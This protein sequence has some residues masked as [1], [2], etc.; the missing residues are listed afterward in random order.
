VSDLPPA[1]RESDFSAIDT[2]DE[3]EIRGRFYSLVRDLHSFLNEGSCLSDIQQKRL[4]WKSRVLD[5]RAFGPSFATEPRHWYTYN[6]GGRNEAQFNI[7][8]SPDYLRVGLGFEFTLKK[9]GDPTIVHWVYAQF[10]KVI[11]R[12]TQSFEQFVRLNALEV[13]WLPTDDVS[14]KLVSTRRVLKWLLQPPRETSWI[15]VGRLL[16]RGRDA[17]I[18]ND[19]TELRSVIES[20]FEG[21]IPIWE[22]TQIVAA[23][24]K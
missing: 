4:K 5:Q 21:F 15:F 7:G 20:V 3:D 18:L 24:Y 1:V 16:R 17:S 8:L 14:P 10:T 2:N 11:A 9:G 12:D 6:N 19:P 23:R 13:E 22:Q